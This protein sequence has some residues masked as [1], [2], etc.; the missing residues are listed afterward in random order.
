MLNS[1]IVPCD[2]SVN[3][4]Q[5]LLNIAETQ[6]MENNQINIECMICYEAIIL[7]SALR[8]QWSISTNQEISQIK[9]HK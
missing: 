3:L 2:T 7:K 5:N 9:N 1:G 4:L 6:Q 8:K